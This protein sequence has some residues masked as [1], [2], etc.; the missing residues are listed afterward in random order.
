MVR[1]PD[2]QLMLGVKREDLP[3]ILDE[4]AAAGPQLN[5]LG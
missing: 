1:Y 2:G 4:A 3:A 5:G